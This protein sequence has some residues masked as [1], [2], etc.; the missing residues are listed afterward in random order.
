LA[1]KGHLSLALEV[2]QEGGH[3]SMPSPQSAVGILCG[4]VAR[5]E[6]QQMPLHGGGPMAE[7]QHYIAP[8]MG[9]PDRL[10]LANRWL[11]GAPIDRQFAASPAG[12]A[13]MRT[14]TAPT[15]F[16]AGV[17]DNVLPRRARAVVNF[18]IHPADSLAAVR[19]HVERVVDD[20][21]VV[22][23]ELPGAGEP[24]AVSSPT[25]T[26]YRRLAR[27]LREV[28]P[29]ALVAPSLTFAGTDSKH[30]QDIAEEVYRFVPLIVRDGDLGRFH[31]VDERIGVADYERAIRFYIQL[32]RNFGE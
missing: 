30:F 31:G 4:A 9:L 29:E 3:S 20:P 32:L 22:I 25:S 12:A 27:T 23:T 26:S 1:E 28:F 21:R 6:Q 15:V 17:K 16:H 19:T 14:T 2:E 5:L 7:L 13:M 10:A 11:F 24:S 8:E 18:R